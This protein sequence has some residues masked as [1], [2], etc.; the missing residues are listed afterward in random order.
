MNEAP[1]TVGD[2]GSVA[3]AKFIAGTLLLTA[4]VLMLMQGYAPRGPAGDVIRNNQQQGIDATPLFY[5]E[6]ESATPEQ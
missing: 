4:F 6:L 3:W 2:R 1:V 5:T